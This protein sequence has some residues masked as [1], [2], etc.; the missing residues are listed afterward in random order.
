LPGGKALVRS[1]LYGHVVFIAR[2][3]SNT[4]V[5]FTDAVRVVAPVL[6]LRSKVVPAVSTC[7]YV[8][9]P[10]A[11]EVK[12]KDAVF[13]NPAVPHVGFSSSPM[14]PFPITSVVTPAHAKVA[15]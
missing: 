15:K 4:G 9:L 12:L 8:C 7:L 10:A 11:S 13:W 14:I 2:S 6:A 3:N 1:K 5:V